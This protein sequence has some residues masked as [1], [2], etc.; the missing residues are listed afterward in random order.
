MGY[1]LASPL[2]RIFEDPGSM[3]EPYIQP[4]MTV[5]EPGPG[6]GFF[7]PELARKVGP[8]GRVVAVDIQTR[9]LAGLQRRL[10]RA[11]LSER[12]DARLGTA[13]S[14]S[15]EDLR[16]KVDFT[17]AVAVVHEAPSG[18]WF[19]G[20]VADAM[21]PGGTLLFAEPAGHVSDARFQAELEA[22]IARGFEVADRPAI[23]R[24]QA[25]LLRK[26][27]A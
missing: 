12:V 1:V 18:S 24:N 2:R 25:A 16:E 11:G 17:L 20:Q 6:M 22:A 27:A 10:S 19:F 9:M 26:K 3:V 15:L 14:L 4:G 7:T 13:N 8:R 5:L 21:K 23:R